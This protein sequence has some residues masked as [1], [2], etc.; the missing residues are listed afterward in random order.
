MDSSNGPA[1]HDDSA[2]SETT[3]DNR[4]VFGAR[5]K[6]LRMSAGLTQ[7][8][9][10]SI[11]GLSVHAVSALERGERRRPQV[12]TVRALSAALDLTGEGRDLLMR[13]RAAAPAAVGKPSRASIPLS[14]TTLLGRE[15]DMEIL[16]Q[17]LALPDARIMTLT[18]PGGV[19]KT[20]LA[21]EIAR[22]ISAQGTTRVVFVPLAAIRSPALV[23]PAI[24][25]ALGLTDVNA[26][27]SPAGARIACGGRPLLL[28]LDNFEQ[29]LGAAPV[30]VDLLSSVAS[31]RVL[32]T[33]RAPLRVRG[34][35]ELGVRPLALPTSTTSPADVARS[36]AVRLFV[37]RVRDVRPAFRLTFANGA[38]VAAICRQLDALPLALELAAPWMKA[39]TLENLLQQLEHD[40]LVLPL[41]PRDL[42]ER[43]QTMKATVA[44]SYQLLDSDEQQALRR[45]SVLPGRFSIEAAAAVLSGRKMVPR[46]D[47]TLGTVAR[48]IDNSLLLRADSS[49]SAHP[50][51]EMLETVR[52]YAAVE[53]ADAG[54][55]DDALQQLARYHA[56]GA[57]RAA[58]G[59]L[60]SDRPNRWAAA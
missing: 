60:G 55:R 56:S 14:L 37:E 45:L 3:D 10:A 24:V 15:A 35:R 26:L 38:A 20:R 8:R 57:S 49:M 27:A 42:P 44:W 12:D 31:L 28:V 36:P 43:Q 50:L 48:L 2:V 59:L 18:G 7:E 54:E 29:V 34:E 13:A 5:L 47:S 9:L 32:V 39:L 53:L 23:A 40:V 33:S 22:A 17:W 1:G 52:A 19:G 58:S 25:E 4:E 30:V 11:S 6:A 51:Y 46:E 41:G 21:L 16:R